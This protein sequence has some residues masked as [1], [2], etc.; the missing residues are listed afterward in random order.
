MSPGK[1]ERSGHSPE[2]TGA[3]SV[4]ELTIA[5]VATPRSL[6]PQ[7]SFNPAR[8]G[9]AFQLHTLWRRW[10]STT[11][12]RS[13][14]PAR[15]LP[16][17]VAAPTWGI[18]FWTV[19]PLPETAIALIPRR[20]NCVTIRQPRNNCY[21]YS[22]GSLNPFP[23]NPFFRNRHASQWPQASGPTGS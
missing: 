19:P 6:I 14:L 18:S 9:R 4:P 1:G 12:S 23:S 16:V 22:I 10:R 15:K 8:V 21:A 11:T 17:T 20:W 13:S 7:P 3:P 5:S 2:D